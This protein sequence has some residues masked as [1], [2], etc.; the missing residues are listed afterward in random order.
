MHLAFDIFQG[1]GIAAAIGVRP[2]LP[3]LAV[4]ALAAG[5]VQISFKGTDYAFLQG[6]PFLL[7]MAVCAILFALVERRLASASAQPDSSASISDWQPIV[8]VL[9]AV[10]LAL[11]AL[12]FAG[13]LARGHYT[14]W[15]GW[16]AGALCAAIGV[17]ATAPL[18]RRVRARLDQGAAAALPVY[19]EGMALVFAVLSV[20]APPVGLVVLALMLWLIYSGRRRAEQK[21]AGLR[22]LR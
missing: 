14:A 2:F 5:D 21:F 7:A 20:V 19:V 10:S 8:L 22:I 13:S 15:P 16:I 6:A 12:F 3:S 11:G 1:I 9:A 17:F 18:L 4:G